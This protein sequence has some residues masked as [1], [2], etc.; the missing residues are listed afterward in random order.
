M[1][2]NVVFV[3]MSIVVD[4]FVLV[5]ALVV[6]VPTSLEGLFRKYVTD[7]I[8]ALNGEETTLKTMFE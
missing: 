3:V 7:R 5:V 6:F 1:K 4:V 8:S 2:E